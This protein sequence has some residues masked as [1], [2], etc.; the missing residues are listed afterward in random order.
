MARIHAKS[1]AHYVDEFDFSGVSNVCTID[2]TNALVDI[3]AFADTD[4]TYLEGKPGF[5]ASIGGLL[6][7][8]SG[9]YDIEMFADL[10]TVD[11]QLGIY[12]DTVAGSFGYEGLTNPGDQARASTIGEAI[13]LDVNW[14][15]D[16]ALNRSIIL[17]TATAISSTATGT[18]Y[19]QGAIGASQRGVAV[20]R[21]LA[22]PSGSGSNDLVVTIESDANASAGGETTRATFT[23][24]NQTSTAT[25]E[26]Q[27]ITATVTDTYW[28]AVATVSGGGSRAFSIV[29]AFGV[30]EYN[31]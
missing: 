16:N 20:L 11:R 30:R 23:T 9:G 24:L 28:R 6:D 15:G 21:L 14:R 25:Y 12:Q 3:T 19:Q 27:E 26:V 13:T 18:K 7:P 5:T 31:D 17:Y 22:A 8:A 2:V 1:V 4:M 29:I 10:T